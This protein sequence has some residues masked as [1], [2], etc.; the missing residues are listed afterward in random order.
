MDVASSRFLSDRHCGDLF[1]VVGEAK[2]RYLF[3]VVGSAVS[4]Q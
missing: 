4:A 2:R 3:T 1:P